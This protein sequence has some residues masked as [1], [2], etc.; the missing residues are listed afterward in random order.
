ME[1]GKTAI[2]VPLPQAQR[3]VMTSAAA[4]VALSCGSGRVLVYYILDS[5]AKGISLFP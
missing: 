5:I 2:P 3:L 1:I 4:A